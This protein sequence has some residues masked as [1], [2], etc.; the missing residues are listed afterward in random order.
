MPGDQDS[1]SH[2]HLGFIAFTMIKWSLFDHCHHCK[3]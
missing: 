3:N 2:G 1:F